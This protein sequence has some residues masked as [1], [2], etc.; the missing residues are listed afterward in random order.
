MKDFK[1][2]S[3]HFADQYSHGGR[4]G[5]KAGG[6][7]HPPMSNTSPEFHQRTEKQKDMD[8]ANFPNKKEEASDQRDKESGPR[9]PK[10]P[11]FKEG[12]KAAKRKMMPK[13]EYTA[14]HGTPSGYNNY[15]K[16]HGKKVAKK[17]KDDEGMAT[18]NVKKATGRTKKEMERLGLKK[19]GRAR[20]PY[21]GYNE[22][23]GGSGNEDAHYVG[24]K[25]GGHKK[26]YAEG[27][28]WI[29][30]AIKKPGS[31]RRSLGVKK[32]QKIPQKKLEAAAKKPGKMGKRARLAETLE[33]FHK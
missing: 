33:G 15:V 25:K 16:E 17:A 3:E 14:K 7:V 18:R 2:T 26:K 24:A 6:A 5:F 11:R 23:P 9:G 28:H 13:A 27:G 10:R 8:H 22:Q 4:M 31:L 1:S 19:G 12:G 20:K 29:K 30:D 21:S 32:G